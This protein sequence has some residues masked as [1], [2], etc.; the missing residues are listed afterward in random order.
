MA[1]KDKIFQ[2]KIKQAGIFD[3][4]EFYSF[5]YDW[6]IHNGYKVQEKTY[7]EKVA[8]DAKDI[9]VNWEA[10]RKVSDYFKF[11]LK[12]DWK[13][14]G[15]KKIKI[16]REGGEADMNSGVIEIKFAAILVKD[17]EHKW[18]DRP[19]WKFSR[20]ISDKYIIKNRI[21][22]YEDVIMEELD[23][24]IAQCKSFLAIEAKHSTTQVNH[25]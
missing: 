5:A 19:L 21:D 22:K 7:S 3:F 20:G 2:G 12:M 14:L 6:L 10:S 1:E 8:G 15:M 9:D 13:I 18:E 23:E 11:D 16:K 24:L 17:Y 4:K 25:F